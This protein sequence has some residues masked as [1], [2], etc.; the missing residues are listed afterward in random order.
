MNDLIKW[1]N[2]KTQNVAKWIDTDPCFYN[3][4]KNNQKGR[5]PYRNVRAYMKLLGFHKTPDQVSFFD[6]T[7]D[8]KQLNS[9][10]KDL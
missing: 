2:E 9:F 6:P 3:I 4:A 7:L 8:T 10:I 5:N 1:T